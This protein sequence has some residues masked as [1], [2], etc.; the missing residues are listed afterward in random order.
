[1]SEPKK[2]LDQVLD[3]FLY[4]PL[5][6]L[7]NADE[8]I[9]NLVERGRQQVMMARMFGQIAV[10]KGQVKATKGAQKLQEQATGVVGQLAASRAARPRTAATTAPGAPVASTRV[11]PVASA[12]SD[13][14]APSADSLAIPDYDSLSASQVVPRL[15]GLSGAE[16]DS[17]R[18]YEAAN[19]GRK[20]ILA[21]ITSLQG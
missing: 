6:L 7:M 1:V 19:R 3:L 21:K 17:V 18:A 12:S 15:E 16:L 5:G 8:V 20:T 13:G 4:A 2:P 11:A 14:P 10:Q 9:P